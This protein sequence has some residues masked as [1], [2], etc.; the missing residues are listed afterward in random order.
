VEIFCFVLLC[1][2]GIRNSLEKSGIFP[3]PELFA[4]SITVTMTCCSDVEALSLL[5]GTLLSVDGA[6]DRGAVY[7]DC[8]R[9]GTRESGNLS[10]TWQQ[11]SNQRHA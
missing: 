8:G 7:A 6:F 5:L 4:V 1:Y 2:L 9:E 10:R 3:L 11:R